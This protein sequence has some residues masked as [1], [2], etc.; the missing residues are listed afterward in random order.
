MSSS[1]C[2]SIGFL[3][4]PA[5]PE[6]IARSRHDSSGCPVMRMTLGASDISATRSTR[7][8]PDSPGIWMS[9]TTQS[10]RSLSSESRKDSALSK[11]AASW[12]AARSR[13]LS[14]SRRRASS[15]TTQMRAF[16]FMKRNCA[17]STR[18]PTLPRLRLV[19]SFWTG[20]DEHLLLAFQ[21]CRHPGQFREAAGHHL[22]HDRAAVKFHGGLLDL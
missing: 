12:P 19:L 16:L 6:Y 3:K 8:I 2:A 17:Y 18:S 21:K 11:Q 14:E 13:S 7:S 1:D 20:F 4:N 22:R 5:A 15:S 10:Q 9:A